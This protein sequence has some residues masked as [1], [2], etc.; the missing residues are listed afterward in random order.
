MANKPLTLLKSNVPDLLDCTEATQYCIMT[1][2]NVNTIVKAEH[3]KFS[4][5]D[6]KVLNSAIL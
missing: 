3:I 6:S 5:P 2:R 4:F 1:K